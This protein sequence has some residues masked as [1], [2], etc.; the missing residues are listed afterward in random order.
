MEYS[1][2]VDGQLRL[3]AGALHALT[4][5]TEPPIEEAVYVHRAKSPDTVW[6]EQDCANKRRKANVD[7]AKRMATLEQCQSRQCHRCPTMELQEGAHCGECGAARLHIRECVQCG[8]SDVRGIVCEACG[9]QT[10]MP[11]PSAAVRCSCA[12]PAPNSS[13]YCTGCGGLTFNQTNL[14]D[15]F[16]D[17]T[18]NPEKS[19]LSTRGSG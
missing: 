4:R 8:K 1:R 13:A 2:W 16:L 3:G 6:K 12:S 15:M 7:R 19:T 14:T 11:Y 9:G 18:Q 10:T 5:R 17:A